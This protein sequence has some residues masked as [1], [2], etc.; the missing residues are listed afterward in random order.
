MKK[1]FNLISIIL[2]AVTLSLLVLVRKDQPVTVPIVT[3]TVTVEV[4]VIPSVFPE[5]T[6][7]VIEETP[8]PEYY[9]LSFVGDCTLASNYGRSDD[10]AAKM[11]GDFSYPFSNVAE[12]L[13][14][15]DMTFANLECTISDQKLYKM[16]DRTFAFLCPTER[17]NILKEGSIEI[18]NTA[19]N[20]SDDF[21]NTGVEDTYTALENAQIAYCKGGETSIFITESG[22]RIGIYCE[23][24]N[25]NIKNTQMIIDSTVEGVNALK[26]MDVDIIMA[27]FHFGNEGIYTVLESESLPARAAIDAGATIVYSSHPHVLQPVEEYNGGVIMYSLGNFTFGGNTLP[28]D[29]D[30]A[31]VQIK[32]KKDLD[33][34]ISYDGYTAIPCCVSSTF[35]ASFERPSAAEYNDY[36]PTPYEVDSEHYSRVISKLDGSSSVSDFTPDYSWTKPA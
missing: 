31:I 4:T 25:N 2:V 17:L 32:I 23:P 30:T 13:T 36:C 33:G 19:N 11:D 1:V 16:Y 26:E 3:E 5:E 34:S 22:L 7:P 24:F 21:G 20:H 6:A 9:T 8:E 18:V 15:D 28:T 29:P 14:A 12:Y 27:V 10:Y 35:P